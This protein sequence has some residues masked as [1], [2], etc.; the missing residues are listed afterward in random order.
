MLLRSLAGDPRKK[1]IVI[2]VLIF[3]REWF[4]WIVIVCVLTKHEIKFA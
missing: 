4:I 1:V 3:P 2:I